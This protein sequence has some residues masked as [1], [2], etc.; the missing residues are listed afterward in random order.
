MN[1]GTAMWT[2]LLGA[3]TLATL[4]VTIVF[5]FVGGCI[6][7]VTASEP[8][9]QSGGWWKSGAMGTVAALGATY[10]LTPAS[11]VK[12][13][14]LATVSGYLARTVLEALAAREKLQLEQQQRV[15]AME[16]ARDAITQMDPPLAGGSDSAARATAHHELPAL[17][18]RLSTLARFSQP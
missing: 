4:A 13:I 17:K 2:Q 9:A 6:Q 5:G 11:A 12:L 16:L 15:Q 1:D 14:G 7:G 3:S 18:A 8:A 10:V